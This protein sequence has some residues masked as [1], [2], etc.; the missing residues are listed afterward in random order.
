M[1]DETITAK[2]EDKNP[3]QQDEKNS[4]ISFRLHEFSF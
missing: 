1:M 4:N 2:E 3:Q